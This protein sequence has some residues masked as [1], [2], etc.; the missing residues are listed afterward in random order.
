MWLELGLE[1]DATL[2]TIESA[3]LEWFR[4]FR[5]STGNARSART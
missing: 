4:D 3:L 1:P 5:R 2:D